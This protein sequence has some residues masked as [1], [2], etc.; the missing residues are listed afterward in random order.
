MTSPLRTQL[1]FS[2]L[3]LICI[4]FLFSAV[5]D[6][7][8]GFWQV[9]TATIDRRP[10]L[11]RY[12]P[13]R[14]L[15][16]AE[17]PIYQPNQRV[18]IV[19]DVHGMHEPLQ[20]LLNKLSYNPSSDTL[21]HVGDIVAKGPHRG[22]LNVLKFMASHNITGVRGNHDQKVIEW[23]AWLDWITRLDGGAVWLANVHAA[24]DEANPDDP[25]EWAER[26]LKKHKSKWSRKIPEGWKFL[27]D[28]YRVARDMT[29]AQFEYLTRLP[30]VL[31][32][33]EAH[34]LIAHA[35]ILPSDPRYKPSHRRQPLATVPSLPSNHRPVDSIA[36]LRRLQE[37]S[38]LA[39]VPQNTDP[40]VTLNMRGILS[41]KSV[42][43]GKD[44]TP[45]SEVWNRDMG[46]CTGF[47][48]SR[49]YTSRGR[50]HKDTEL[51]CFPATVVYGHAASRGL[52][53]KRWS[54]GLDSACVRNDRLSALVLDGEP[55]ADSARRKHT[56]QFGEGTAQI[57]DVKCK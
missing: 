32:A 10:D 52:D 15:S 23:R 46:Y 26:H 28:H 57:V 22:S 30:L 14:T 12:V 20:T 13:H 56:I 11:G 31:H 27:S 45:W 55:P 25:E 50:K 8:K 16:A 49:R 48:P 47:E 41:D 24:A 53:V 54:V 33:P 34:V 38:L 21:I 2:L 37:A 19:G 39:K 1:A 17:F 40:W 42:T 44:G 51:P 35:G 9:L 5:S 43:R 29:P 18:L 6:A 36:A 3:S 7:T 4:Y